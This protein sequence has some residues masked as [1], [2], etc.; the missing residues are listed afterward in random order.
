MPV[1]FDASLLVDRACL[2]A[3]HATDP[4]AASQANAFAAHMLG[5]F[6]VENMLGI[7]VYA[8]LSTAQMPGGIPVA[9]VAIGKAGA[10]NAAYLAA[11]ILGAGDDSVAESLRSERAAQTDGVLAKDAKLAESLSKS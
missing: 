5:A 1:G 4:A 2:A 3:L 6:R 9:T 10:K 8:L 11:Q 7:Y